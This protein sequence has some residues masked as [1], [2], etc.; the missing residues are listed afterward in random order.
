MSLAPLPSS[1]AGEDDGVDLHYDKDEC[2]A[3]DFNLGLFPTISTVTYLS[4]GSAQSPTLILDAAITDH[5]GKPIQ[6]A[7]VSLP[8]VGK[9]VAFDGRL[10]HGAPKELSDFCKVNTKSCRSDEVQANSS[11]VT[12]LV[13]IW[14]GHYPSLVQP[15]PQSVCDAMKGELLFDPA[16]ITRE[17]LA[18]FIPSSSKSI[19]EVSIRTDDDSEWIIMPF[20]TDQSQWGK[21]DDEAGLDLK[22]LLPSCSINDYLE[23]IELKQ[24]RGKDKKRKAETKDESYAKAPSDCST[25]KIVY[26]NNQVAARLE[27]EEYEDAEDELADQMLDIG[28]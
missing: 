24:K 25:F 5:V 23:A 16:V 12:F 14:I 11:R 20:V 18:T 28:K 15:L 9:H 1:L 4:E 3:E 8:R 27:Y 22:M 17:G 6:T 10:L 7:Y 2:I 26:T 21:S 13:N 19:H